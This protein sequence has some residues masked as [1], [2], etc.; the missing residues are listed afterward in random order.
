MQMR[1]VRLH[2]ALTAQLPPHHRDQRVGNRNEQNDHREAQR[3]ERRRLKS[4]Q[5]QAGQREPEEQ[6]AAVTLEDRRRMKIVRQKPGD[7]AR[8][9][10]GDHRN[11][12]AS[13]KETDEA[14][15]ADNDKANPC[16]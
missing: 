8:Q 6:R 16:R 2:D 1:A 12:P 14:D 7:R 13:H 9:D 15:R 10:Q 5:R 4:Q 3:D 11:I